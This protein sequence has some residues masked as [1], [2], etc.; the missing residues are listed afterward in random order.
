MNVSEETKR[1]MSLSKTKNRKCSIDGCNNKHHAHGL[2]RSHW[3]KHRRKNDPEYRDRINK[4]QL[5][6]YFDDHESRK[7]VKRKI[8]K[9]I[10]SEIVTIL[11]GKCVACDEKFNPKLSQSNMHI[12]HKF[13]SDKDKADLERVGITGHHW[14]IKRLIKNNQIHEL[15]KKFTLLCRDCNHMEGYAKKNS[16][17]TFNF[18]CWLL[19]EGQLEEA[20]Q[21]DPKLK[22]IT[23]FLE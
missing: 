9:S 16:K 14:E 18:I 3:G 2:C 7:A 13:Y 11:G 8:G 5:R 21:D 12:H 6:S 4:R 15:R 17:K 1:K 20:L 19:G 23:E 22:K 10:Q